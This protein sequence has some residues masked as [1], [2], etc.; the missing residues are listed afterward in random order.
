MKKNNSELDARIIEFFGSYEMNLLYYDESHIFLPRKNE[1][2]MYDLYSLK[3]NRIIGT[4]ISLLD[5][6][7]DCKGNLLNYDILKQL[8]FKNLGF[9]ISDFID[10][11]K[12]D[13]K[14]KNSHLGAIYLKQ[15]QEKLLVNYHGVFIAKV[16]K[17]EQYGNNRGL[18]DCQLD[19]I[20]LIMQSELARKFPKINVPFANWD[21]TVQ[22]SGPLLLVEGYENG[23]L[24]A[25][26][27]MNLQKEILLCTCAFSPQR[28]CIQLVDNQGNFVLFNPPSKTLTFWQYTNNDIHPI[29][30]FYDVDECY[31]L[32]DK[33]FVITE[34][35]LQTLYHYKTDR[36][37]SN[38]I[39][40]IDY[41]DSSLLVE[42]NHNTYNMEYTVSLDGDIT[43][44]LIDKLTNEPYTR[45]QEEADGL[46]LVRARTDAEH[47]AF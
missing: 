25:K 45:L 33:M 47:R 43:S 20:K 42:E 7:Y 24:L 5:L 41:V 13:Q 8:T 17:D 37:I 23:R 35:K 40:S 46:Y 10:E 39:T 27:V 1:I 19:K 26:A 16:T 14:I 30:K 22:F 9:A 31:R 28:E 12:E 11:N 15:L 44:T 38:Q 32:T 21:Y 6:I 36:I 3:D 4:S 34:N 29:R 18:L 2:G